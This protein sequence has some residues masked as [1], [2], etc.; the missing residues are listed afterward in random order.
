MAMANLKGTRRE[1]VIVPMLG[2]EPLAKPIPVR[3]VPAVDAQLRA[4]ENRQEFI[5]DA[6]AIALQNVNKKSD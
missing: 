3:F 2:A 6:V 4:M 1:N 5:R